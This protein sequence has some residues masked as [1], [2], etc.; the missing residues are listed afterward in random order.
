MC[1]LWP[2]PLTGQGKPLKKFFVL[3]AKPLRGRGRGVKA[4]PLID[5]FFSGFPKAQAPDKTDLTAVL[6]LPLLS[7][8]FAEDD[9]RK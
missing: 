8:G 7:L 4:G 9:L 6:A 1:L 5:N 3:V 2:F